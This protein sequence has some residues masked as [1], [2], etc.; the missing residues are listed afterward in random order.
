MSA[1]ADWARDIWYIANHLAL[2][3]TGNA[4][5]AVVE[6]LNNFP[7]AQRQHIRSLA[8]AITAGV[9]GT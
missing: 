6:Q 8:A 3:G 9:S 1:V 7:L 2:D 5:T 4:T